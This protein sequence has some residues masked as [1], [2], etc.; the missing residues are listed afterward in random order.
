MV[1]PEEWTPKCVEQ[2]DKSQLDFRVGVV[3]GR[4]QETGDTVVL[5]ENVCRPDVT[6]DER[7]LRGFS[8]PAAELGGEGFQ[9][10]LDVAGQASS[11]HRLPTYIEQAL[12]AEEVKLG[13]RPRVGLM[14][15]ADEGVLFQAEVGSGDAV[16]GGEKFGGVFLGGGRKAAGAT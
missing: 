10:V 7:G 16:E 4:V 11:L 15:A 9:A 13:V 1:T 3:D 5:G 12:I 2:C 14:Q 8:D 6:V